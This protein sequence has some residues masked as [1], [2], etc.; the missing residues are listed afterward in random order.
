MHEIKKSLSGILRI[1]INLVLLQNF[2]KISCPS[3]NQ[4]VAPR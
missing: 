2:L 3:S 1:I 4:I